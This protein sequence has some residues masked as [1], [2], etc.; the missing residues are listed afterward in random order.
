[1]SKS[2]FRNTD[3]SSRGSLVENKAKPSR[4][5]AAAIKNGRLQVPRSALRFAAAVEFASEPSETEGV[6]PVSIT[7][8]SGNALQ[9]FWFGKCIH[10]LAG[11]RPASAKLPFDYCHD[12]REVLGFSDQQEVA[13]E[14][15]VMHGV[16]IPHKEQDRV[17]EVATKA[18]A[19]FEWQASI[20]F[21]LD[22]LILEFVPEGE[23]VEVNGQAFEGP[24][25]IFRE[26]MLRGAAIC[27]YGYDPATSVQFS[28]NPGDVV[29]VSF[30]EKS[31]MATKPKP[32]PTALNKPAPNRHARRQTAA[33]SRTGAANPKNR[34]AKPKP[35]SQR[36]P[37]AGRMAAGSE[38]E[39]EEGLESD[40]EELESDEDADPDAATETEEERDCDCPEG[41][42]CNCDEEAETDPD[43]ED[44]VEMEAEE[45]GDKPKQSA[46][47]SQRQ[48]LQRYINAFGAARGAKWFAAG[49]TFAQAQSKFTAVLTKQNGELRKKVGELTAQVT[50]LG[51]EE[52]PVT[53]T[54]TDER[55]KPT[56]KPSKLAVN[57]PAGAAKFAASLKLPK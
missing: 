55:P 1:M 11:M 5:D 32:K 46:K 6:I 7:A 28:N 23:S 30:T 3:A 17:D 29:A 4:F 51:G 19:G 39:E 42:E 12:D 8:R 54:S 49:L 43:A 56:G 57:L 36:P 24:G 9:H 48:Q 25:V 44:P 26:W 50:A 13:A 35:T 15:L 22:T 53:F 45:E 52:E 16:L 31:A 21:D 40:P 47:L 18:A 38:E 20:Y 37:A 41:E 2:C 34:L 27:P 33:L 10:D 14:G